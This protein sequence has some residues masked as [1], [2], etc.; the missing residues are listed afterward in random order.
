MEYICRFCGKVCKN[1]NSLR[2]HERLCKLNPDRDLHSLEVMRKNRDD[3]NH[4][5]NYVA[6]NKGLTKET[7]ESIAR[8]AKMFHE[9]HHGKTGTWYGKKH[10]EET[11]K[12]ISESQK[13]YYETH[14][15]SWL[16][17]KPFSYA[18]AYF[19]EIF[20]DAQKQYQVGRYKLDYAWPETKTYIE[21]D[22]E[23]HYTPQGIKHDKIRTQYL[24]ERGWVCKKRIRWR[25]YNWLNEDEKKLFI[26]S[27]M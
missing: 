24:E 6:W 7:N 20:T 22:G 8:Q 23:Q 1:S 21:V 5:E 25:D 15:N 16:N 19:N 14:E 4:S 9:R 13:R 17:N 18:E 11:K 3:W 27:L 2:N 26:Q 10:N 12:K